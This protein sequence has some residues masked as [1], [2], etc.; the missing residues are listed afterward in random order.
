MPLPD[1][2]SAAVPEDQN[3]TMPS[4]EFSIAFHI[5]AHKTATS[6]L[7]RSL[8]LASDELAAQGVRYYGP[9]H[10]RLPGRTISALFGL[11]PRDGV[12]R[13]KRDPQEQLALM[14]KGASRIVFSEENFIGTLAHPERS[15]IEFGYPNANIK[16]ARLARALGRPIDVFLSLRNP[17]A[18]INSIYSQLLRGDRILPFDAFKAMVPMARSD[19]A[20]LV[21]RLRATPGVGQVTVWTYEDYLALFDN[22]CNAMVGHPVAPVAQQVNPRLSAQAVAHTLARYDAGARG[23]LAKEAASAFPVEQGFARFDGFSDR[24]HDFADMAYR[25]QI[26]AIR[27]MAGV[28]LLAPPAE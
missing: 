2:I 25:A 13:S 28:T 22:I 9:D 24:E 4:D 26:D 12:G 3:Q 6:H 15:N 1:Q 19:W 11:R 10:F 5:G 18:M 16:I 7:Q 20:D 17:T 8:L 27:E 23:N 21:A 14:R